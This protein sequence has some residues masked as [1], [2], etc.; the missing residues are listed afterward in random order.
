MRCLL[1][2]PGKPREASREVGRPPGGREVSREVPGSP[3]ELPGGPGGRLGISRGS[4][5][6]VPGTPGRLPKGPGRPL[7]S[8]RGG[9]GRPPGAVWVPLGSRRPKRSKKTH[10]Q[11]VILGGVWQAGI[12]VFHLEYV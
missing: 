7:G 12:N 9:P 2:G 6:E 5:G 3:G 10:F 8:S 11:G 1:G 4:P